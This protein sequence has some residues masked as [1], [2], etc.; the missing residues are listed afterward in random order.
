MVARAEALEVGVD[1]PRVLAS[2]LLEVSFAVSR[3]A[4]RGSGARSE[5]RRSRLE[6]GLIVPSG[7]ADLIDLLFLRT[8]TTVATGVRTKGEGSSARS[9]QTF[10]PLVTL[11]R[12]APLS[13]DAVVLHRSADQVVAALLAEEAGPCPCL[14]SACPCHLPP[15]IRSLPF[16][17]LVVVLLL[18]ADY[19]VGEG[20]AGEGV[21]ASGTDDRRRPAHAQGWLGPRVGRVGEQ[22]SRRDRCHRPVR[23]IN[24]EDGSL[25]S[26]GGILVS[27][28][29][30]PVGG[31][32]TLE[33]RGRRPSRSLRARS[34]GRH[35]TASAIPSAT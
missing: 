23:R 26:R 18:E 1:R 13:A 11:S 24:A 34:P 33:V 31:N 7:P 3:A 5:A 28:Q 6:A 9:A 35:E 25:A 30:R 27:G 8:T 29:D 16:P 10:P 21:V 20:A 17:A 22:R 2:S 19:H 4:S 12:I 15:Q 32:A 14:R